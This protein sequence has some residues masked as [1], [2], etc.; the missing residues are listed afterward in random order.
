MRWWLG[1]LR[2]LVCGCPFTES[3]HGAQEIPFELKGGLIF[4]RVESA[5]TKEPLHFILDSGA[6]VSVLNLQTVRQLGLT[7][8]SLAAVRG[9]G[10]EASGFWPQHFTATAASV[11]LT[12]NYLAVDLSQLSEACALNVDGLIGA[13]FFEGRIVQID[14]EARRIRVLENFTTSAHAEKLPLR[15]GRQALLTQVQIEKAKPQWLRVDTGCASELEWVNSKGTF[16]SAPRQIAVGL[17]P[18]SKCETTLDFA[19]GTI[20]FQNMRAGIH[21]APIF[22]GEMGLVGNALLAR[23]KRVT[24]DERK[25]RLYL[26]P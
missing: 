13:D 21:S 15:K 20:R 2:L 25:G 11:A 1:L 19:L 8:A 16:K 4:V 23:F 18:I 14:Y 9:V 17:S 3:A 6:G 7:L 5:G 22:S 12:T 26:E 10:S 24:F